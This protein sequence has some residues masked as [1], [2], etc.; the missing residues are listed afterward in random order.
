[1]ACILLTRPQE[2][3]QE[4]EGDEGEAGYKGEAWKKTKTKAINVL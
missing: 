2:L 3:F 4:E 1:M